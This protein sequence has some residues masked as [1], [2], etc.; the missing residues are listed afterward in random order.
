MTDWPTRTDL[1]IKT[2][3]NDI[4]LLEERVDELEEW[5]RTS[6]ALIAKIENEAKEAEKLFRELNSVVYEHIDGKKETQFERDETRP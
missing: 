1:E 4:R 6:M 2:L 3:K 5:Q